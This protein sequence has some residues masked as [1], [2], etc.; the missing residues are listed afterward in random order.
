MDHPAFEECMRRISR[1]DKGALKEIYDAYAKYIFYLVLPIAGSRENAEDIT[2]EVF[3][4]IWKGAGSF[5]SKDGH[6]AWLASIARNQAVDYLRKLGRE[7]PGGLDE[8]VRMADA[9]QPDPYDKVIADL[10]VS[11]VLDH[12]EPAEREVVHLKI[13][14]GLTFAQIASVLQAPAGTVAWRYRQAMGK[15]RR[16]GYDEA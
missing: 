12:L 3:L 7:I 13:M 14:G 1:Q 4:K 2:S 10:T 5:Q 15:L 8:V 9:D 16:C 11:Q 6:K